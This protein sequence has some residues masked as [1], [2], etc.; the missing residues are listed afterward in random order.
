MMKEGIIILSVAFNCFICYHSYN[1]TAGVGYKTNTTFHVY[2]NSMTWYEALTGCHSKGVR[3]FRAL[4]EISRKY[5]IY[6]IHKHGM[7]SG[8]IWVGIIKPSFQTTLYNGNDCGNSSKKIEFTDY[9]STQCLYLDL[10][11]PESFDLADCHMKYPFVCFSKTPIIET[12]NT[13]MHIQ[14]IDG[15]SNLIMNVRNLT[16]DECGLVCSKTLNCVYSFFDENNCTF[17]T[18]ATSDFDVEYRFIISS[19]FTTDIATY[20]KSPNRVHINIIDEDTAYNNTFDCGFDSTNH[21]TFTTAKSTGEFQSTQQ[22]LTT[23]QSTTLME[24]ESCP[25]EECN[26]TR[27][28]SNMTIK[29]ALNLAEELRKTLTI[30]KTSL[31]S[32]RRS[33]ECADDSRPSSKA[34]GS[35]ALCILVGLLVIFFALDI[36]SL[37]QN[38]RL[39]HVAK[40]TGKGEINL[41]TNKNA[42]LGKIQI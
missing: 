33:L 6:L 8:R 36:T 42:D 28:V 23:E 12:I 3:F 34:F 26:A 27:V 32:Y 10:S 4:S 29:D 30:D 14:E 15:V 1:I 2:N 37:W 9:N 39:K 31:S 16:K 22:T 11:D 17:G 18:D 19:T 25:E 40:R 41:M 21:T 24:C 13:T 20:I 35:F 5:L 38:C 7:Q